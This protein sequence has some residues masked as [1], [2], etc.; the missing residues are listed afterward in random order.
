MLPLITLGLGPVPLKFH[1]Q[2]IALQT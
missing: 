1:T 2:I